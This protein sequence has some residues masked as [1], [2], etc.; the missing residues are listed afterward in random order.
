M[1]GEVVCGPSGSAKSTLT[2]C[3]NGLETIKDRRRAE[4]GICTPSDSSYRASSCPSAAGERAHR[5]GWAAQA[6]VG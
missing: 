6:A 3:I 4:K 1:L 5:P 2:R